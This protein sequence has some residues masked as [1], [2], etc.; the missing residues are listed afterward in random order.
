MI[1]TTDIE[2]LQTTKSE[3]LLALVM[4]VFL[5]IG[6]VW[7]YQKLDS[8]VADGIV[9][10]G[11]PA[12]RAAVARLDRA[13]TESGRAERAVGSARVELELRRE[14]YRT[15]LDAG[16]PAD[17]LERRYREAEAEYARATSRAAAARREVAA[18]GPAANAARSRIQSDEERIRNRQELVT[19]LLRSALV[20]ASFIAAL[21]VLARL[22]NRGS[23]YLPLGAALVASATILA[24]V[25]A[26]DY[27][28]DY[29]EPFDLGL[30]VLALL[31]AALTV[32]AFASLQR[33]LARRLP[34][35]RVR[36][37]QC[38]FCGFPLGT[39]SHCEGCGREVISSC[40]RCGGPRRVGSLRCSACG[41]A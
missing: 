15:A 16:K 21:A 11:T 6:G 34:L 29:L 19:F 26:V 17:D 30:L 31:G 35:R 18:A 3:K 2:E 28:T 38:P 27:L 23:R 1:R 40:A 20:L 22:R 14:A 33:Y 32:W 7:T 4:A 9:Q 39:G 13:Y 12:D 36:R 25:L 5:L 37:R 41:A 24:F 10:A 8:Y